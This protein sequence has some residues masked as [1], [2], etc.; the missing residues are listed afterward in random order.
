VAAAGATTAESLWARLDRRDT[1]DDLLAVW[2][3]GAYRMW[4]WTEWHR[5]SSTFAA[6]LRDL[7][8][9]PGDRVACLLTNSQL[10]CACV[11]GVWFAGSCLLSL[12]LMPRG[13]SVPNY[14]SLLRRI[15]VRSSAT[16]IL[17]PE[18]LRGHIDQMELGIPAVA[19]EHLECARRLEPDPPG[20]DDPAFVQFTSGS[21]SEPT[22]CILT[23]RAIALQLARLADALAIDPERDIGVVWLPLA[24]DM[25]LFG[26]LLLTYWTGHRVMLSTPERFL[27]QPWTWLDDCARF[28]ATV[29]A[30]PSFALDLAARAAR[31]RPPRPFP[32]RRMV[33]GG[34]RV[35]AGTLDRVETVLGRNG[36]AHASLMPAYGLA[37]AVL[38]VTITPLGRGPR[39]A[40]VDAEALGRG[41]IEPVS[42]ERA[43]ATVPLVS[44]GQPLRNTTVETS[45]PDKVGEIR[46]N[47]PSLAAGY[48][49]DSELTAR[50]FTPEGL[51]TGDL[52][53]VLDGELFVTGRLDDLLCVGGRNVYAR[54][55]EA[56]V[57][58]GVPDVRPGGCAVVDLGNGPDA[59]LVAIAELRDG[60]S[61]VA[62]VA[63]QIREAAL[64]AAGVRIAECH[65]VPRGALPKTPSG[66]LQRFRCR[67][68]ASERQPHNAILVA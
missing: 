32:M 7:G 6:G 30:S 38:A 17:C 67:E 25:G 50:R 62:V 35:D 20:P 34:E 61:D 2:D 19:F 31:A 48:L 16:V 22:G 42:G 54:D 49:D 11:L 44:S 18:S 14:A 10:S 4:S 60:H 43:R 8:V 55:V 1:R 33:I 52:G 5:R 9:Q 68:L 24:H 59:R 53:F 12:P 45:T 66:K 63:E 39:I 26:C 47:S 28:Q 51:L 29:S 15:V 56:A 57:A 41:E 23:P 58:N 3:R 27:G 37:E 13:M 21:T 36:L 40:Q 64:A 65:L 46:V